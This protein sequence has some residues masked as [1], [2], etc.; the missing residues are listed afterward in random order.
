MSAA[1]IV[2]ACL[3]LVILVMLAA[4]GAALIF[5]PIPEPNRDILITVIGALLGTGLGSVTGYWLGSSQSSASKDH[6]IRS[7]SKEGE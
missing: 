4:A 5:V 2:R 7:L 1:M 3:S 6:T